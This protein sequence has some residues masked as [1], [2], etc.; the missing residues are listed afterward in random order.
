MLLAEF[1]ASDE[2]ESDGEVAVAQ[3]VCQAESATF[4]K[5]KKHLHLNALYL[6]G[7]ID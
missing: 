5:P 2:V 1:R 7:F 3:W 4:E 6:K